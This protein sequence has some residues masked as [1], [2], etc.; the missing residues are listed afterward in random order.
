MWSMIRTDKAMTLVDPYVVCLEDDTS[1]TY[2]LSR[3]L[4]L[5]FL[6]YTCVIWMQLMR[7]DVVF[8]RIALVS[9]FCAENQLSGKIP[10]NMPKILFHPKTSG[11]RIR[12][13]EEP[14]GGHTTCWRGPGQAA[15]AGGVG[16]PGTPSASLFAYKEPSDLKTSSTFDVFPEGVPFRRHHQ[17]PRD[18]T[19]NSVLAPCRDGELEEIIAIIITIASPSTIHVSPI[20][21]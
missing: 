12:D 4:L 21:E 3:T 2:L 15:P 18:S 14:W 11:A 5:L 10:E 19:R 8:S 9:T 16:P 13:G 6:L 1:K 7:T 20:Y 17:I